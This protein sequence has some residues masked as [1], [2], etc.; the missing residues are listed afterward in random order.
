M[1]AKEWKALLA[2]ARRVW[3]RSLRPPDGCWTWRG[4]DAAISEGTRRYGRIRVDGVMRQ[5]TQLVWEL[6]HGRAFPDGL[7][8]CHTC[9]NPVCVRPTHIYAGSPTENRLDAQRRAR[10]VGLNATKSACR[11]GHPYDATNTHVGTRGDG[12]KWRQCIQCNNAGK[13]RRRAIAGRTA[14]ANTGVSP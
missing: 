5:V 9:D 7:Y 11:N 3:S 4:T 2:L 10:W 6:T 8:A 14:N 1:D 12:R 13:R